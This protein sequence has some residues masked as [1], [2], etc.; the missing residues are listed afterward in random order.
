MTERKTYSVPEL[1]ELLRNGAQVDPD[2]VV[3]GEGA[4]EDPETGEIERAG[5]S[6]TVGFYLNSLK[7]GP[8]Q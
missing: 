1:E 3:Y 7:A 6:T 8:K 2:D 4:V 5:W